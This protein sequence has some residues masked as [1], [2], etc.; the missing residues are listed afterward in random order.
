MN[1]LGI[2]LTIAILAMVSGCATYHEPGYNSRDQ[3]HQYEGRYTSDQYRADLNR[4]RVTSSRMRTYDQH[5]NQVQNRTIRSNDQMR[6]NIRDGLVIVG[7]AV[8]VAALLHN[9]RRGD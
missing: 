8:G 6:R 7:G 1:K 9:M 5:Q 4:S 2:I 3:S